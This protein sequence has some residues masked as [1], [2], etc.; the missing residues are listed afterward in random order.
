MGEHHTEVRRPRERTEGNPSAL[1]RSLARP[2]AQFDL[3]SEIE[4]LRQTESWKRTGHNARELVKYSDLRISLILL[5]AGTHVKGHKAE[6]RVSVHTVLGEIRLHLQKKTVDLP[7]GQLLVLD[8]GV[9]HDVEAMN[10]SAFLL[11]I[12]WPG[13]AEGKPKE[14]RGNGHVVTKM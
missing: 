4:K 14:D 9:S 8:R 5:K 3:K 10:E 12:S 7:A 2:D 6:A 1:A 13:D 11:S